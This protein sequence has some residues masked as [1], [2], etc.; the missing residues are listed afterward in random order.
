ML[1]SLA[2]AAAFASAASAQ[3]P[4]YGGGLRTKA[5]QQPVV[6]GTGFQ[7]VQP[8]VAATFGTP[9][10]SRPAP[11]PV[12]TVYD[13]PTGQPSSAVAT[14][15]V[16]PV[17]AHPPAVRSAAPGAAGKVLYFHKA[18]NA[19][20][21][22]GLADRSEVAMAAHQD[23]IPAIGVPDVTAEPLGVP[24]PVVVPQTVIEKP[25]ADPAP[26][27]PVV[28]DLPT[29]TIAVQ[30]EPK[31]VDEPKIEK[32][33]PPPATIQPNPKS[34][35]LGPEVT[36]LPPRSAI[37][38]VYDDDTLERII[39]GSIGKQLGKTAEEQKKTTPFPA[40]KAMVPPGT[41]YVAKTDALPPGHVTYEPGFIVH[42]RLHFEERN[43]ERYGWDLGL[44][45]PFVSTI[46]FYKNVMLWPSSLASSC[47]S[48]ALD[49]NAGKCLPGS[50]T[51]YYLY[52]QG[53]TITGGV[54][55]TVVIT[56]L[57]FV[58]P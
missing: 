48:G 14:N 56:G 43:S 27:I 58:I 30:P 57:A 12:R 51:P 13:Q 26:F 7:P 49:T 46:S 21:P 20:A 32:K 10:P 50:P 4:V 16:R 53:L 15:A 40:L 22:D 44:A 29:P 54:A 23:P 35:D 45:T 33:D 36:Q 39:Y 17:A 47:V 52:P 28:P 9:F 41:K 11:G 6:G 24:Q 25:I 31:K 8:R 2:A 3:Q 18:E 5:T 37:F 1:C 38:T 34:M 42:R 19:S 55:E